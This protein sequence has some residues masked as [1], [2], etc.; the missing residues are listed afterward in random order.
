MP[1]DKIELIIV[2]K[3]EIA[4]AR[5]EEILKESN[6]QFREGMDSSRG[7]IYFYSTGPKFILTFHSEMEKDFFL[8]RFENTD[9]VHEIYEPDW[10]KRKD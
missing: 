6:T 2:F 4:L 5:A 8:S 3:K 10:D 1:H 7:K 9:E